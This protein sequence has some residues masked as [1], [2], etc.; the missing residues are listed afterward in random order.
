MSKEKDYK[1]VISA[2]REFADWLEENSQNKFNP[3]VIESF[4]QDDHK[5]GGH[6]V[7]SVNVQGYL[8]G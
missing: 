5:F 4:V 7:I 6:R 1:K 3:Y 8:G 2:L